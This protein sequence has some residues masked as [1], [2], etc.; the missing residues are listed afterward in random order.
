MEPKFKVGD[1]VKIIKPGTRLW[2]LQVGETVTVEYDNRGA[3]HR[4]EIVRADG[5][6]GWAQEEEIEEV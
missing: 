5:R 3:R 4:Y 1:V 6:S 2:G